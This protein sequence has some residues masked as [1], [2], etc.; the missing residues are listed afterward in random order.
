[1]IPMVRYAK[2]A[3]IHDD[4]KRRPMGYRTL[5]GDM[6]N[7]LSGGQLQRLII[8]RALCRRPALLLMNEATSHLDHITE[9]IV[10]ENLKDMKIT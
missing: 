7:A 3:P 9:L 4:I 6:E 1:M 5:V 8:A 10:N 2:T